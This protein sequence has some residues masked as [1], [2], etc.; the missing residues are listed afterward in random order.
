MTLTPPAARR[1]MHTRRIVCEGYLRDDGLWDI[2]ARL[3]DTK[4]Y[5]TREAERGRRPAG[6]PVHDMAIRLTIDADMTVHGIEIAMPSHPYAS[7]TGAPEAFQ[8]LVGCRIG[9]GWRKMIQERAGGVRGCTHLRE[10][11]MPMA[12][13]AFQTLH[14]WSADDGS[15]EP[16]RVDDDP[17]RVLNGCKAWDARGE[18]VARFYPRLAI[19]PSD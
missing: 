9:P 17:G 13:V 19:A 12:T 6:S 5:P 2:E 16:G 1:P 15:D 10:L 14:G 3:L 8:A 11:L 4:A 18:M 7:C